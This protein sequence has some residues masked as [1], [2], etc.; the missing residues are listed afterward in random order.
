M[1]AKAENHVFEENQEVDALHKLKQKLKSQTG[2]SITFALLLF[3]VCAVVGSAV[4]VAGTAAAGRM[5]KIAEMDQRYYAVNSAA[6]LLNDLMERDEIRYQL[7]ESN[8]A[9]QST[10]DEYEWFVKQEEDW[11]PAPDTPPLTV[12]LAKQALKMQKNST[13]DILF[14]LT[15][16]LTLDGAKLNVSVKGT[17][18][19][20]ESEN[21]A[22][23]LFELT[24]K[25]D[26]DA[27]GNYRISAYF[28]NTGGD[29]FYHWKLYDIQSIR[30]PAATASAGGGTP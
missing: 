29:S 22:D 8:D 15:P 17:I 13:D 25:T 30:M 11:N 16:G 9:N 24:D 6:R 10:G 1:E 7:K 27:D 5:S 14:D 19:K 21:S 2:A 12:F 4:L 3:L 23:L 18:T 20:G 26:G 28:T